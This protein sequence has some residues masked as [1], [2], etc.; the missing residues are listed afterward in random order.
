MRIDIKAWRILFKM[1][2]SDEGNIIAMKKEISK[3]NK[4]AN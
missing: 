4:E 3:Q 1:M 2:N